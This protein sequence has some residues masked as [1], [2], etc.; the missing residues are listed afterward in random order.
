MDDKFDQNGFFK[1]A[2]EEFLKIAAIRP[3]VAKHLAL[4]LATI[5]A[6]L[7]GSITSTQVRRELD[8]ARRKAR[9]P[10]KKKK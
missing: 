9:A 6:K 8:N 1:R 2:G 7:N 10:K 4:M 5:R 3:E